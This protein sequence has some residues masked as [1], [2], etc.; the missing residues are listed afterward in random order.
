MQIYVYVYI[1]HTSKSLLKGRSF[2]RT[3][4]LLT[5]LHRGAIG[6]PSQCALDLLLRGLLTPGGPSQPHRLDRVKESFVKAI[7]FQRNIGQ[8]VL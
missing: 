7:G 3:A 8:W 4:P 5:N 6:A 1:G 2:A